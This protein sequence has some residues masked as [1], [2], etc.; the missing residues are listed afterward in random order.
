MRQSLRTRSL[1]AAIALLV[2]IAPA[3]ATTNL[4]HDYD[5]NG[6]RMVMVTH[7]DGTVTIRYKTPRAGLARLGVTP[8]TLLFEGTIDGSVERGY[9]EGMTSTRRWNAG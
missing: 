6:S 9:I 7:A 4:V 1:L 2:G 5:H 8:G 3:S